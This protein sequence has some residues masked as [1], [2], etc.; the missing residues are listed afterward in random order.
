MIVFPGEYTALNEY[1]RIERSNKFSAAKLK[2]RETGKAWAAAVGKKPLTGYPLIVEF[3]WYTKD[4]RTD[5][6]NIEFAKKFI[7]DGLVLAG[8]LVNDSRK[9][10]VGTSNRCY[11][12]KKNPRVEVEFRP[13]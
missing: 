2:E 5:A 7:L 13:C 4:E 1:I 12:D 10:I 3:S 9:Y 11:V 6:D 8:V